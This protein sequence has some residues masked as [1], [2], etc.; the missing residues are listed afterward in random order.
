MSSRWVLLGTPRC[1][2][3]VFASCVGRWYFWLVFGWISSWTAIIVVEVFH[4]FPQF[5]Q[6]SA[7][8]VPPRRSPP[9]Y[10][11]FFPIY[12]SLIIH[13]FFLWCSSPNRAQATWM[14]RFLDH[15][16]TH[17]PDGAS[18]SEW[19]TRRRS[20]YLHNTTTTRDQH[21]MPSAR[22][23]PTIPAIEQPQTCALDRT[24]AVIGH[25]QFTPRCVIWFTEGVVQ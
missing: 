24:V 20:R 22:F 25:H 8:L 17:T 15:T 9:L 23:E 3:I 21:L 10:L 6:T 13:F 12:H 16:Q 18:L 1:F 4:G 19:S 2:Q 14:L 5:F 11:L 7:G